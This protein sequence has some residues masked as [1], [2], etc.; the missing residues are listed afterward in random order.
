MI[1]PA[2]ILMNNESG[3]TFRFELGRY[4]KEPTQHE[5]STENIAHSTHSINVQDGTWTRYYF[6]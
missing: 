1:T 4:E 2:P 3:R 5:I 6:N